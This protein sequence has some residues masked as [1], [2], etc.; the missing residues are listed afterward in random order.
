MSSNYP[1]IPQ[2]YTQQLH[3]ASSTVKMDVSPSQNNFAISTNG[4]GNG[5]ATDPAMAPPQ[6]PNAQAFGATAS[7]SN[8]DDPSDTPMTG[9][10]RK[11]SKVSRACDECRRKKVMFL[12][13]TSHPR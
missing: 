8:I 12:T 5:V 3:D 6:T 13:R 10:K 4:A 11:R 7:R 2:S 1:A 9:D